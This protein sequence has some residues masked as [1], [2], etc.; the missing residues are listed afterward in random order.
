MTVAYHFYCDPVTLLLWKRYF[1]SEWIYTIKLYFVLFNLWFV[2]LFQW[3]ASVWC[4][5][6]MACGTYNTLN[7]DKSNELKSNL[8]VW[9]FFE[10]LPPNYIFPSIW[11]MVFNLCTGV[12]LA[13]IGSNIL[14]W[15]MEQR[16][17]VSNRKTKFNN[18]LHR[19]N[20]CQLVLGW[21][22]SG[23]EPKKKKIALKR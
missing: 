9:W 11:F 16:W 6:K 2:I 21:K 10:S 5:W 4:H 13:K 3:R 1:P 17:F 15:G 19:S 20:F 12:L 22:C 23:T 8:S 18:S 14:V 7:V